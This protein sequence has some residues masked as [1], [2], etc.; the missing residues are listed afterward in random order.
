MERRGGQAGSSLSFWKPG[1]LK[2]GPCSS[3][4]VLMCPFFPPW[5]PSL[6]LSFRSRL[7]PETVH[8]VLSDPS[9]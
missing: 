4:F 6:S 9:I 1:R 5:P 7:L 3:F 2:W 8:K